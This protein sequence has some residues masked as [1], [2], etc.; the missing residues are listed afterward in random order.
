MALAAWL[1]WRMPTG[2]RRL[3]GLMLFSTQLILKCLWTLTFFQLHHLGAA[4]VIILLLG[5]T[6]LLTTIRFGQVDRLAATL[7][8]PYLIWV[9]FAS[10]LNVEFF[11]LN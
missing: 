1:I 5:F 11:R 6:I 2:P 9:A 10:A 3:D 7:F 8:L 4:L